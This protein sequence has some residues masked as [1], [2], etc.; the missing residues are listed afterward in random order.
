[1]LNLLIDCTAFKLRIDNFST[2][3]QTPFPRS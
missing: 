2:N 3:A 1:V